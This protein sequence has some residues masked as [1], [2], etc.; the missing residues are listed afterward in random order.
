MPALDYCCPTVYDAGPAFNQSTANLAPYMSMSSAE[1]ELLSN[2]ID[3]V[4][5][6]R[7]DVG[8]IVEDGVDL[9]KSQR[10]RLH[11]ELYNVHMARCQRR[12][13]HA[14]KFSTEAVDRTTRGAQLNFVKMIANAISKRCTK[15]LELA[16]KNFPSDNDKFSKK[17]SEA[18]DNILD[19]FSG[20]H[21]KCK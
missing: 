12:R 2:N 4:R 16:R 19:C 3:Q 5:S 18:K 8:T 11:K 20:V 1:G 6:R 7:L 17:I 15:E 10:L 21:L 14:I 9:K 13:V